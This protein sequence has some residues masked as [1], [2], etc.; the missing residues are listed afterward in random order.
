[1]AASTLQFDAY[2]TVFHYPHQAAVDVPARHVLESDANGGITS[3]GK[4]NSVAIYPSFGQVNVHI[5]RRDPNTGDATF[6]SI[7]P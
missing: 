3:W 4:V 6:H 7:V 5:I 1:M 2:T